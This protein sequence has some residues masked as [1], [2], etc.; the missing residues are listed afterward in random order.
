MPRVNQVVD[1]VVERV[2][3]VLPYSTNV[4]DEMDTM[5][6]DSLFNTVPDSSLVVVVYLAFLGA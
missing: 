4:V 3:G 6:F 1:E 2:F 5:G